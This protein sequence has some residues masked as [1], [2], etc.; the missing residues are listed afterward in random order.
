MNVLLI[1]KPGILLFKELRLSETAW[2]AIRFY[3]PIELQIGCYIRISTIA[4]ALSLISDLKYFIRRYTGDHLLEI[5]Q[6]VYCTSALGRRMYLDR[7]HE[8]SES[9]PYRFRYQ[10]DQDNTII[11]R[12]TEEGK[13]D[14]EFEKGR[15]LLEV[16]CTDIEYQAF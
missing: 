7:N 5:S 8:F 13:L 16:W 4:N 14:S 3:D 1:Q 11:R 9:W 15:Y 10:I 12:K 2:H 6:G